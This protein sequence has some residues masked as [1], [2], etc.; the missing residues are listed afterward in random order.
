MKKLFVFF[1]LIG[2]FGILGY[3]VW[4][5]QSV[6]KNIL[7]PVSNQ[8][9][10]FSMINAPKN[11][12]NGQITS[13]S[14]SVSWQ[15]RVSI[16]PLV[17]KKPIEVQQGESLITDKDGKVNVVFKNYAELNISSKSNISFIQTLPYNFVF[18]QNDGVVDYKQVGE[19]PISIRALHLIA[20]MDSGELLITV[21]KDNQKVNLK[22]IKG[23]MTVAFN[24][25]DTISQVIKVNSGQEL[26]Y[27]DKSRETALN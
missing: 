8:D 27:N 22:V 18:G 6:V 15:S 10:P 13:I 11:S 7:S 16:L 5:N 21:D 1:F 4:K 26:I 24:D 17:I 19:T 12:I 9:S 20:K 23:S 2:F 25:V 14:G 3:S